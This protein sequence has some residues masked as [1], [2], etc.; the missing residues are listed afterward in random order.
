MCP[1]YSHLWRLPQILQVHRLQIPCFITI[2]LAQNFRIS[3]FLRQPISY[4]LLFPGAIG[5]C[6]LSQRRNAC[7]A[8]GTKHAHAEDQIVVG[9]KGP[10]EGSVFFKTRMIAT[11]NIQPS[12]SLSA[13]INSREH[14]YKYHKYTNV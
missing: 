3:Q 2:S 9:K 1:L 10:L 14:T 4:W 8:E 7:E 11:E 13:N 5:H 12:A 6:S